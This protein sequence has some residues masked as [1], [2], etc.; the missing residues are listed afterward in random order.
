MEVAA[1]FHFGPAHL[2]YDANENVLNSGNM[3]TMQVRWRV[4][5]GTIAGSSL[6]VENGVI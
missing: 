1:R 6:A 4:H 3:G 5:T 2:G